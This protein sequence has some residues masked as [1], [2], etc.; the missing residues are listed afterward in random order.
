[1]V[2]KL[3]DIYNN[4]A[5][6]AWS[7]F[8]AE[9]ES[10]DEFETSLL[11][12]IQKAL[13][14]LWCVYPYPFRYKTHNIA[15]QPGV[16]SYDMPDGNI[17]KKTIGNVQKYSVKLKNHYLEYLS[18]LSE[19]DY[20]SSIPEYFYIQNDKIIF[21][22]VPDD[23]YNIEIEY[24]TLCIGKDF[25]GKKIF[26]LKK[27]SD[28]IEIP[29]KYE[30]LFTNALITKSMVYAIAAISDEN[31]SGYETQFAEAYKRL[32]QYCK[33]IDTEVWITW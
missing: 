28:Y 8:D 19:V 24:L 29:E 11:S 27:G 25:E 6:Q 15:T 21:V 7:M 14:E 33:G 26:N 31:Y 12:S 2:I 23:I 17:I 4:V 30:A 32:I 3:I 10:E 9:I 16:S 18:D 1:M 13:T 20:A 5:G 22:P